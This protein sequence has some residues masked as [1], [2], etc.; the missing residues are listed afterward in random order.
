MSIWYCFENFVEYGVHFDVSTAAGHILTVGLY[1]LIGDGFDTGV[2]GIVTPKQ[3]LYAQ[4]LDV[5]ILSLRESGDLDNLRQKWFQIQNCP[6]STTTS[7]AIGIEAV[8]GLFITFSVIRFLLL[9]LFIWVKR[10]NIK[11]YLS[12]LICRKE[13]SIKGKYSMKTNS[14]ETCKN[15]QNHQ[16]ALAD[17]QIFKRKLFISRK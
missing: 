8:G 6:D 2:F 10:Y 11:N 15:A 3:W 9:L 5:N 1:I 4:D 13:S 17:F 16:M 7:T 14:K 12:T